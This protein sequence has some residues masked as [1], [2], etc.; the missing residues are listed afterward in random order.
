MKRSWA[1][2]V[3]LVAAVAL[4]CGNSGRQLQSISISQTLS[5]Q[6]IQFIATGH[7]SGMPTTVTPLPVSWGIGPFAPP[8]PSLT[9]TL[10]MQPFVFD[11]TVSNSSL[12]VS[13]VAPSN[14]H[15]PM[16][17]SL[18]FHDMVTGEAPIQC[19]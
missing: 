3:L 16:T 18:P 13:V 17:G 15:A 10:T 8:P 12:P 6:Q 1:P 14:P 4:S 2:V 9:Y 19:P 11:C 5:G 7:F